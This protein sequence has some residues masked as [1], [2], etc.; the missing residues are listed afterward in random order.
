MDA[1]AGRVMEPV[2]VTPLHAW[3]VS[4]GASMMNAGLWKRPEHYGD[5]LA[6]ALAVRER[7][8]IIDVSTLGKLHLSGPDVAPLLERLYTNR[9]QKLAVGRVRYGVMVNDEGVVMDDGTTARLADDFYYMTTT[10]SGA[11]SVHEWIEWWLQSGWDFDVQ[12]LNVTE[13]ARRLEH[14]RTARQRRA[15]AGDRGR[16]PEPRGVPLSARPAGARSPERPPS[17]CASGSRAS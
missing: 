17:C 13:A 1:L 12:V 2:R 14:G 6:E 10:S 9:W 15:R 4:H 11:S 3:H 16:R 7:V 8:G 5:P